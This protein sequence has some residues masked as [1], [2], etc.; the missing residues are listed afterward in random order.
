MPFLLLYIFFHFSSFFLQYK[1][2]GHKLVTFYNECAEFFV[3]FSMAFFSVQL[4][5]FPHLFFFSSFT[6]FSKFEFDFVYWIFSGMC[7]S[8]YAR[9]CVCAI[10]LFEMTT[11]LNTVKKKEEI[12]FKHRLPFNSF[13]PVFLFVNWNVCLC[14]V[15]M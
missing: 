5:S 2:H 3:S 4:P 9:V 13:I 14:F 10:D 8:M 15:F 12:C 11:N 6:L 7:I 1:Q